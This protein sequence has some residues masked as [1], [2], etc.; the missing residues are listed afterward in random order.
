M[1]FTHYGKDPDPVTVEVRMRALAAEGLSGKDFEIT[2]DQLRHHID[3][4][5]DRELRELIKQSPF[6]TAQACEIFA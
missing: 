4:S 1:N 6:Q 5:R 2:D 3:P